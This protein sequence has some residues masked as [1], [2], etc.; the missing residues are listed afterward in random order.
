MIFV[1]SVDEESE[2]SVRSML[3]Q[4][5]AFGR[6]AIAE[7]ELISRSHMFDWS[8]I[9]ESESWRPKSGSVSLPQQLPPTLKSKVIQRINCHVVYHIRRR[10][11]YH[12][13]S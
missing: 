10:E 9:V 1:Q 8:A 12:I 11:F 7:S 6:S 5:C 2:S 3:R 4:S 13:E